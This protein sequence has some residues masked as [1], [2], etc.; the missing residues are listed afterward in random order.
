MKIDSQ[1]R[2]LLTGENEFQVLRAFVLPT[3]KST[4]TEPRALLVDSDKRQCQIL[5]F[6]SHDPRPQH[7]DSNQNGSGT[8]TLYETL[9]LG[10]SDNVNKVLQIFLFFLFGYLALLCISL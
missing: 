2:F 7:Q 10:T 4:Y 9:C 5:S 1:S 6:S 3:S 8:L